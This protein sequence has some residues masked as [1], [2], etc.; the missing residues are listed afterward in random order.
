MIVSLE[1][2]ASNQNNHYLYVNH[3]SK[4]VIVANQRC[5]NLILNP[6]KGKIICFNNELVSVNFQFAVLYHQMITSS[7]YEVENYCN[8]I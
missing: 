4:V 6:S 7:E 1:I 3:R 5:T 8:V 2:P